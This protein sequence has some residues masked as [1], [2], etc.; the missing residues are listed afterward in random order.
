MWCVY[1]WQ[2][3]GQNMALHFITFNYLRDSVYVGNYV[4]HFL[5]PFLIY[6]SDYCVVQNENGA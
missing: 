4:W 1:V 3:G 2:K 6:L 5:M